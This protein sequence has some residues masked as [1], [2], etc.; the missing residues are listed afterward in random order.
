MLKT[1]HHELQESFPDAR[2]TLFE[3]R[4]AT[5]SIQPQ[6]AQNSTYALKRI[7]KNCGLTFYMG[8]ALL[9]LHFDWTAGMFVVQVIVCEVTQKS[10]HEALK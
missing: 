4:K 1:F 7:K 8:T 6:C 10:L 5:L 9:Y 3:R 2:F